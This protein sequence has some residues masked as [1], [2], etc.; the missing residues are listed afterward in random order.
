M[1]LKLTALVSVIALASLS[2]VAC[3]G[4]KD[5]SSSKAATSGSVLHVQVGPSPE[6]IDPALNSAVDGANMILHAFEGLLKFDRNN[7]V[8][9][10][11]AEK[12]EQSSDGLTWTFHLRNG[13]KWS[14]GSA[15]TANDFVYSWKRVADPNT[16]APYG[17]D[18]L[19]LVVGFDEASAGDLDKLGV[20][21]PDANT[22]VVHLSSPCI[23]FDKIAAFAVLVPVQKAT[24]DAA[25]DG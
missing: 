22:F 15:L 1:K 24:I 8:V 5:S 17:Y 7:N 2:F 9:A 25:G 4:K 14:D 3:N 6:T 21:A 18:L 19:N 10:G 23:F 12:W 11:L 16:A 20:E 13:L